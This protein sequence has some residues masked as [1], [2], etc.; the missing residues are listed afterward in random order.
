MIE[1][2]CFVKLE[3]KSSSNYRRN[4]F[5]NRGLQKIGNM[6][7][8]HTCFKGFVIVGCRWIWYKTPL[9]RH[10]LS[11]YL[12]QRHF[13]DCIRCRTV[14]FDNLNLPRKYFPSMRWIQ[15]ILVYIA[16]DWCVLLLIAYADKYFYF[17]CCVARKSKSELIV[18]IKL[19]NLAALLPLTYLK[20]WSWY[21][22]KTS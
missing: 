20:F 7:L 16:E 18:Q 1:R 19:L 14:W 15:C 13:I 6:H 22:Q 3:Q 12:W 17:C 4:V 2:S 8:T 21:Q 9:Y 5:I 10:H 11:I